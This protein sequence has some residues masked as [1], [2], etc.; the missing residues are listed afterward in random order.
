MPLNVQGDQSVLDQSVSAIGKILSWPQVP[1]S[2]SSALGE[3]ITNLRAILLEPVDVRLEALS[4]I[5]ADSQPL[6][7]IADRPHDQHQNQD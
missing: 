1:E 5:L 6:P 3:L 2:D 7:N 4:Q